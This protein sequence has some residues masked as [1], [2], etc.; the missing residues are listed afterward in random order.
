MTRY[1]GYS[2]SLDWLIEIRQ[3]AAGIVDGFGGVARRCES[4]DS[5]STVCTYGGGVPGVLIV[6]K[7]LQGNQKSDKF[8]LGR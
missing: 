2:D 5:C 3:E 8:C 4:V 1:P 6:V 7:P